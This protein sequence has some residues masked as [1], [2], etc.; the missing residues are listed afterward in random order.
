MQYCLA[1]L[2]GI[3]TSI[4]LFILTLTFAFIDLKYSGAVVCA[5]ATFA[6]I[7]VGNRVKKD[8]IWHQVKNV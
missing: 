2:S 8:E 4:L 5:A 1:V 6:A 7:Q 3:F